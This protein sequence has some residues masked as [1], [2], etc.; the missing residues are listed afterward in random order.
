M[1]NRDFQVP[2]KGYS[3]GLSTDKQPPLTTEYIDNMCPRGTLEKK[4][5]LTQRAGLDKVFAQQIG[6]DTAPIVAICSVTAVD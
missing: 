1:A 5:R 3:A 4:I 6:G 2:I